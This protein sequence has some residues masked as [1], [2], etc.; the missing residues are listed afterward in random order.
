MTRAGSAR[1]APVTESHRAVAPDVLRGFAIF[2]VLVANTLTFAYPIASSPP[3][4]PVWR[5]TGAADAGVV[6]LV[7]LL[8]EGK[9]YSLLSVL[10]GMGL[11]LQ[12][13][14]ARTAGRPFTLFYLRRAAILFAIGVA[15]AVLLYAADILAFYAI[16]S[17]AALP[18]RNLSPRRLATSALVCACLGLATLS[19]YAWS[20]PARPY[21]GPA[22]W[23]RMGQQAESAP[24]FIE[25]GA[26]GVM[27]RLGVPRQGFYQTMADEARVYRSGNWTELTRLRAITALLLALPSK[28]ILLG[29]WFLAF[30]LFGMFLVR[31]AAAGAHG[32]N[33]PPLPCFMRLDREALPTC[34]KLWYAGVPIGVVLMVVA[35]GVRA[36]LP[37]MVLTPSIYWAGTFGGVL[38]QA[39]GYA[40]GMLLLSARRPDGLVVRGLAAVGRT[41]LSNYIAQSVVLGFVFYGT[42]LGLFTKLTALPVVALSIP[43]FALL[44]WLS[45]VWLRGFTMGPIEWAWR[46]VT[47]GT[48][49][50]LRKPDAVAVP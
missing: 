10:F 43:V 37:G 13:D 2:G 15:H 3:D 17:V 11:M 42:G 1:W 30:F 25:R 26:S 35:G 16:I 44:A 32:D 31:G 23:S 24:D 6:L 29:F 20:H 47:Y 22:D 27:D 19:F 40:G 41:A 18:F 9:F 7:G 33:S 14:R 4:V 8:V 28:V 45:Q 48:R 38:L 49:L 34:R 36:M 12:A 5:G 50:P 46:C 39:M 21:P